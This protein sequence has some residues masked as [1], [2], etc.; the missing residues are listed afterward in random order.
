[1][2]PPLSLDLQWL[3]APQAADI[4]DLGRLGHEPDEGERCSEYPVSND[5]NSFVHLS[6]SIVSKI[7]KYI[8]I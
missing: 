8:K 5:G 6:L 3:G 2:R 7:L 1:M 4:A